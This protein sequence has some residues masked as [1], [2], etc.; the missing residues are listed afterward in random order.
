MNDFDNCFVSAL[1]TDQPIAINKQIREEFWRLIRHSAASNCS[2]QFRP[3]PILRRKINEGDRFVGEVIV[4]RE[5]M[6]KVPWHWPFS[7]LDTRSIK[8]AVPVVLDRSASSI[9]L[10]RP[11]NGTEATKKYARS[12]VCLVVRRMKI[13]SWETLLVHGCQSPRRAWTYDDRRDTRGP[14]CFPLFSSTPLIERAR[15]RRK[16]IFETVIYGRRR[17]RLSRDGRP[18]V[19]VTLKNP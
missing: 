14:I 6:Q 19:H 16:P 3:L 4:P 18:C 12:R 1:R 10:S 5:S 9:V 2:L 15:R 11:R 17:A 8:H 13:V 7:Y